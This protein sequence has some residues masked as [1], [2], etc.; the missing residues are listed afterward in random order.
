MLAKW[1]KYDPIQWPQFHV[2]LEFFDIKIAYS[3]LIW[4]KSM[5]MILKWF[6]S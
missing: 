4:S 5:I 1:E 3:N 6:M 2:N